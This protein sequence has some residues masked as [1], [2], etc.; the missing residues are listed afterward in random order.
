MGFVE[1]EYNIKYA[2]LLNAREDGFRCIFQ[3]LEKMG[4]SEYQILE[5]GTCRIPDNWAGDGQSTRLWN[6]FLKYYKGGKCYSVDIDPAA[7]EISRELV[8]SEY[9]EVVCEDS[10]PYLHSLPETQKF[11]LIYLDSYD[12]NF[13]NPHPSSLH[14]VKELL[15]VI[16]KNTTPS[17]IIVIDDHNHGNGK[18]KYICQWMRSVGYTKLYEGYQIVYRCS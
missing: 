8:N 1:E 5:T 2:S 15:S 11:D 18:G 17:T 3:E 9:V 4:K 16:Y 14:H 13:E 6:A 10:V 7:C 12:V